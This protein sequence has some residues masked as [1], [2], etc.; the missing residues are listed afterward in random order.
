MGCKLYWDK[1]TNKQTGVH[2]NSFSCT[3]FYFK[4]YREKEV[5]ISTKKEK[6]QIAKSILFDFIYLLFNGEIHENIHAAYRIVNI[7]RKT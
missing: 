4:Q 1:Q 7:V 2:L 3:C 6:D 5:G